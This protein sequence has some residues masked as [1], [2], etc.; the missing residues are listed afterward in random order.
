MQP[1]QRLIILRIEGSRGSGD[2][3]L[4]RKHQRLS[5]AIL[6]PDAHVDEVVGA[7][8]E[9]FDHE[10]SVGQQFLRTNS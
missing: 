1:H 5:G 8:L 9:F 10:Q 7:E 4:R 2:P 6:E 3:L